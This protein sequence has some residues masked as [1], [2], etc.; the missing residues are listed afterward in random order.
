M[1]TAGQQPG[2]VLTASTGMA[3][4]NLIFGGTIGSGTYSVSIGGGYATFSTGSLTVTA[5]APAAIKLISGNN[6]AINPGTLAPLALTAEVTDLGGNPS[7][8]ATVT[9][10]V[11]K[12]VER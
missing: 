1:V 9:W 8:G 5:G 10:S 3:T 12:A 6:Q 7:A 11:S 2:T 4:C